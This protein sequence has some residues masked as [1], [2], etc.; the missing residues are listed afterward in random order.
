MVDLLI[1]QVPGHALADLDLT[2]QAQS[3]L[4]KHFPGYT[5]VVGLNDESL[6]G[7]MTIMNLEINSQLLGCPNWGYVLKLSR[8][9]NDPSLKC[10]VKAGGEIL[11]SANI[12]RVINKDEKIKSIDGVNH[13]RFP[14]IKGNFY[15]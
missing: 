13:N 9:Y 14:L 1:E 8:V 6:G 12:S 4:S 11:E 7:V 15:A 3:V 2:H 10:V 5:W